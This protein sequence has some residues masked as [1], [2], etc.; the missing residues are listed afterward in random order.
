MNNKQV[1]IFSYAH[2]PAK[3]LFLANPPSDIT[4][5]KY[6]DVKYLSKVI[7]IISNLNE[8]CDFNTRRDGVAPYSKKTL[9]KQ[10]E[11]R[12]EELQ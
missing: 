7:E 1:L 9:I 4:L 8:L 11:N 10:F 2:L 3:I 12:L 5:N 6:S